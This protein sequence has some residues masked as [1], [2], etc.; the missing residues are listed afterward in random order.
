VIGKS[1]RGVLLLLCLLLTD[2]RAAIRILQVASV[3]PTTSA[4]TTALAFGSNTT[5]GSTIVAVGFENF[6]SITGFTDTLG[7]TF[8]LRQT[9]QSSSGP[10]NDKLA[11]FTAPNPAGGADTVTLTLGS[12]QIIRPVYLI[13]I[14]GAA[15]SSY[16]TGTNNDQTSPGTGTNGVTSGNATN[17]S[18]P[19]LIVA[20]SL[21]LFNTNAPAAGSGFTGQTAAWGNSSGSGSGLLVESQRITT[22]SAIAATF[23]AAV[24]SEH[25]TLMLILNEL[26]SGNQQLPLLNA[27]LRQ[28]AHYQ[29]PKRWLASTVPDTRIQK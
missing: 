4:T 5:A 29:K 27:R 14:G 19:A 15:A 28:T 12:S 23:T 9:A 18:Q 26:V 6:S 2:A 10:G 22:T 7:N 3:D 8:T 11:A 21:A 1:Y 16:D 25:M 13:E 17:T 24:N 20:A